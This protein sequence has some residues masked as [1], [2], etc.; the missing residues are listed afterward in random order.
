[1]PR[2]STLD[3]NF[4]R[5]DRR[6]SKRKTRLWRDR[7]TRDRA[8]VRAGLKGRPD[9]SPGLRRPGGT[10]GFHFAP[11]EPAGTAMPRV[12]VLNPLARSSPTRGSPVRR[13]GRIRMDASMCAAPVHPGLWSGRSFRPASSLR[14]VVA[15][16]SGADW[17][18][19]PLGGAR[20]CSSHSNRLLCRFVAA[21]TAQT[22]PALAAGGVFATHTLRLVTLVATYRPVPHIHRFSF[23]ACAERHSWRGHLI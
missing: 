6:E 17:D 3:A 15:A 11:A 22:Q 14:C 8:T 9:H 19:A 2:E 10:D 20:R 13:S 23:A 12:T 1:M 16:A 7:A 21:R 5:F 4:E 18:R